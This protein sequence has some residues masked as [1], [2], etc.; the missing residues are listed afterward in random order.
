MSRQDT[1]SFRLCCGF[2]MLFL[3]E[4]FELAAFITG[5][6][7]IGAASECVGNAGALSLPVWIFV[8]ALVGFIFNGLFVCFYFS[9]W[10]ICD[11]G[12]G[13][14]VAQMGGFV[15]CCFISVPLM[16]LIVLATLFRMAWFV[17]GILLYSNLSAD[18]KNDYVAL[19]NLGVAFFIAMAFSTIS[20]VLVVSKKCP[21]E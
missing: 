18:C 3:L 12:R 5:A 13:S 16:A 19:A 2:S 10:A 1:C 15:L 7:F 20:K 21:C 11:N 8:G 14:D 17:A 6:S 4:C 9:K